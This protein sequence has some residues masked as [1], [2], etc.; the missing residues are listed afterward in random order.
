MNFLPDQPS[1]LPSERDPEDD[2]AFDNLSETP[3]ETPGNGDGDGSAHVFAHVD[4]ADPLLAGFDFS[5]FTKFMEQVQSTAIQDFKRTLE[6]D[7]LFLKE[8][9][10]LL[11]DGVL[12]KVFMAQGVCLAFQPWQEKT[13]Q[14][15]GGK[16]AAH[17]VT[18]EEV[19]LLFSTLTNGAD[20]EQASRV[21]AAELDIIELEWEELEDSADPLDEVG[22]HSSCP[23]E[24]T[25]FTGLQTRSAVK[26]A[27]GT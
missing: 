6:A 25:I 5:A 9:P 3:V 16:D 15:L 24:R 23:G 22:R 19:N 14:L 11:P 10:R 26:R 18:P 20:F 21:K 7:G 13:Y 2:D 8:D 27:L 12:A 17:L 1:D 4:P